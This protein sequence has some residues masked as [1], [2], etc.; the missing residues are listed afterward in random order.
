YNGEYFQQHEGTTIDD[1]LSPFIA[2]IFMS[3]F[4]TEAKDKFE[5]FPRLWFSLVCNSKNKLQT[6]L[7]NPKDKIDNNEKSGLYEIS[8]KN[9]DQIVNKDN[10]TIPTSPLFALINK[11]RCY[12]S[13]NRGDKLNINSASV[14]N[15]STLRKHCT[16]SI[17][18]MG[19]YNGLAAI[20]YLQCTE[21]ELQKWTRTV[22]LVVEKLS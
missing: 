19:L 22:P 11:D 7:G 2:N 21:N 20:D 17:I 8:C 15:V 16:K 6:L 1:S 14:K 4:E 13:V 5:Y 12:G 9:C 18:I 10:G 3:K